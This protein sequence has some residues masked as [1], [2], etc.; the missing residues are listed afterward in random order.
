[1]EDSQVK[2]NSTGLEGHETSLL[3]LELKRRGFE[4]LKWK[5]D[6]GWKE[7]NPCWV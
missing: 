7:Q 6:E 3:V 4:V 1:M 5:E 2:V